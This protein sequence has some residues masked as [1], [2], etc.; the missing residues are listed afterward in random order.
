MCI[1]RQLFTMTSQTSKY[2]TR[3]SK[4]AVGNPKGASAVFQQQNAF[5]KV[6][7]RKRMSTKEEN[8]SLIDTKCID[9]KEES[10]HR[11]R[12]KLLLQN[13]STKLCTAVASS[14]TTLIMD[15]D[16]INHQ[17]DTNKC[18][19][20]R[21]R[22]D[23]IKVEFETEDEDVS[24]H[25]VMFTKRDT[26]KID[27]NTKI[28]LKHEVT[29]AVSSRLVSDN[30]QLNIKVEPVDTDISG[31]NFQT[32]VK[33]E[34]NYVPINQENNRIN[35]SASIKSTDSKDGDNFFQS[36]LHSEEKLN[37]SVWNPPLWREQLANIMEMRRNRDAPVDTMGCGVISDITAK[38]QDYR[39]QVLVSLM[40]S[41]QTKDQVTSDAM[42][43]LRQHGCSVNNI[44][45]TSDEELGKLIY[46]VGF[47][48]KKVVYI[49]K[50]SAILARDYAGDI[51]NTIQG[52]CSLPG[53][54]PKMA[55]L[56]MKWAWDTVTG[57]GVDTHVHRISNRL[58]WV[59]KPTKEPEATRK[60]LEDW[61]PRNYWSE[62]NELLVGFG[63]QTCLP[64][65]PNCGNCLNRSV[66]PSS[67]SLGSK[68]LKT[69]TD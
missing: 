4:S 48:N 64:L 50:A 19:E 57:I 55:H 40:L 61:L 8:V 27:C 13:D 18:S 34:T 26:N 63:Q 33:L 36:S 43:R 54:G 31:D 30:T 44:L 52:L 59:P 62:V 25:Q 29:T 3:S 69:E 6:P 41:S 9:L 47:W 49:K 51:P 66:C 32:N 10:S 37:D 21:K 1:G 22:V 7:S 23:H 17:L 39:Y 60:A 67:G 42:K 56:V 58:G 65:R 2:F 15:K 24:T 68:S 16:K 53:V 46:P 35:Y 5:I 11:Q 20:R 12:R 14:V 28:N 45:S 38:P